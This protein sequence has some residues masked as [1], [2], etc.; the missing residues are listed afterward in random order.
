MHYMRLMQESG[1]MVKASP[2]VAAWCDRII[3]RPSAKETEPPPMPGR[4]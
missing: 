4:G 1:E 3:V 2:N